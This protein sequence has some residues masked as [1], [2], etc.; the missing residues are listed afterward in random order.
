MTE[1]SHAVV[2]IDHHEA[3]VFHFNAQEMD[4]LVVK[5][6]NP[7][8]HIHHKANSMGSGHAPEDK[9]YFLAVVEALGASTAVLVTGPG[10]AKAELVKYIARHAPA[11]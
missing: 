8:V 2:W 11:V 9:A 7:H 3:R 1:H 10:N 4:R 6:D 5:P